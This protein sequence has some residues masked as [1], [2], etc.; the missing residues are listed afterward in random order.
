MEATDDRNYKEYLKLA[1]RIT[2]GDERYMDLLHDV[3]LQLESN[4]KWNQLNDK[5]ER[6]YFISK[7]LSNQ[8]NSNNSQFQRTYR[9]FTFEQ[10][11]GIEQSDI[12]Y[13]ESPTMEWVRERLD[14]ELISNPESWYQI[15][16]F[17]MFI[18]HKKVEKLHKKTRIPKYSIRNT[19]KEMKLW[20][21]TEWKNEQNGKNQIG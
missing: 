17:K 10:I 14:E 11:N 18:E 6:M 13:R 8:F 21:R 4:V 12:E 15:G 9:R 5:K 1:K 7:V 20:L 2:K 3:L 16:L 19:I